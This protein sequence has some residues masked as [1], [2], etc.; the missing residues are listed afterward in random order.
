MATQTDLLL[1]LLAATAA[2]AII[3]LDREMHR[4]PAGLRTLMLVGL[5]SALFTTAGL[6]GLPSTDPLRIVQGVIVGIGFLG[7]GVILQRE[8]QGAV[9]GLTTAASIWIVAA[10]GTTFALGR[11]L[12]AAAAL[13]L[14]IVVLVAGTAL[15][16]WLHRRER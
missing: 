4:K 1:R 8:E 3:G 7:G 11:W 6:V 9:Q 13:A 14:S 12:L 10:L 16:R 2:G 15:E 5:G